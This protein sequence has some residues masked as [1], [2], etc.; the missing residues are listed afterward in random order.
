MSRECREN[1]ERMSRSSLFRAFGFE[2]LEQ[3]LNDV[4]RDA[5]L[6]AEDVA[7]GDYSTLKD[8]AVKHRGLILCIAVPTFLVVRFPG[9]LAGVTLAVA[10]GIATFGL[11]VL[12]VIALGGCAHL[13]FF[14][15]WNHPPYIVGE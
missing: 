12:T 10:R 2:L 9:A 3:Y 14:V 1:V 5:G 7:K 8:F 11:I 4:R 6:V 15:V 13:R